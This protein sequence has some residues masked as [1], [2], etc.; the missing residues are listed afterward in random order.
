MPI[1][2][3][4]SVRPPAS[5]PR[6]SGTVLGAAAPLVFEVSGARPLSLLV[7]FP[8]DPPPADGAVVDEVLLRL[9]TSLE[10]VPLG[11]CR[12]EAPGE[13][14][15]AQVRRVVPIDRPI[16]CDELLR[17]GRLVSLDQAFD[18]LPLLLA[19]KHSIHPAFERYTAGL[20]YDLRIYRSLFD[21]I[22]AGL[23]P[24]SPA[25][26][27]VIEATVL[28]GQGRRFLEFFDERLAALEAIV[29]P[30]TRQEHERHGFYFRRHVWDAILASPFLSR[31][32]LRPRG[33]AGDSMMMQYLY[34]EAWLGESLFGK[35]MHRHPIA[36]AAAQAVRNRR[37]MLVETITSARRDG[38]FDVGHDGGSAPKPAGHDGGSA[39]KPPG[40]PLRFMS[41]A[42][43]PAWEVADLFATPGD[44]D[45]YE[46]TL[47]DQDEEALGEA[48]RRIEAVER[49][50]GRRVRARYIRQSVRTMLRERD[51]P[52]A[53][54]RYHVV[55][56]M[57]LFDYL[58]APVAQAV[59]A[60]LYDLVEPGGRMIVGNF[61]VGNP[62]R[63]YMDYWMD[64]SLLYR[65]EEEMLALARDLPG[66]ESS[67]SF[68][69]T[70]SQM[71][72]SVR[73]VAT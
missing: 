14:G 20:V 67:V 7:R 19:R 13:A 15:D 70:A 1:E 9:G 36:S 23:A 37:K 64:W 41:V 62:T 24:E 52:G 50:T 22:D 46:C 51:L 53:L 38:R 26:R 8:A 59:L 2:R 4:S 5:P 29:R 49:L 40:S 35:L 65:T 43:G 66:A 27:A 60:K 31:T 25:T 58:T 18:Q 48:E 56:S 73:K 42:C 12:F 16:D 54:G 72:L 45:A 47:L 10:S 21:D 69:E 39:P 44:C 33:Y 30:F 61:H 34:E 11:R 63:W 28:A 55:Y 6:V 3:S 68:E 32:N 57:G 17:H 71:F